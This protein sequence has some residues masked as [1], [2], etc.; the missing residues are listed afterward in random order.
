[1][2]SRSAGMGS[3]LS[4]LPSLLS[5]FLPFPF[6]VRPI[7]RASIVTQHPHVPSRRVALASVPVRSLS[8]FPRLS[9]L[10]RCDI[11]ESGIGPPARCSEDHHLA[12]T[13]VTLASTFVRK[14]LVR[15][16]LLT[17][18]GITS[19]WIRN[20]LESDAKAVWQCPG[21][22]SPPKPRN[23][24]PKPRNKT[25]HRTAPLLIFR[26]YFETNTKAPA[27]KQNNPTRVPKERFRKQ[28][29]EQSGP[30][31][32]PQG[33]SAGLIL[34]HPVA[35]DPHSFELSESRDHSSC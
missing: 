21:S 27:S 22:P 10:S 13:F 1:H 12:S 18:S 5:L 7:S 34:P 32:S 30:E 16:R 25:S 20:H 3:R 28:E 23:K 24:T 4:F 2:A 35:T 26:N 8:R 33:A 11:R 9:P 29:Q 17:G 15:K 19:Y 6:I 31:E 14:R